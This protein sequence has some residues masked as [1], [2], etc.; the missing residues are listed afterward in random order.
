MRR[1]WVILTALAF[2]GVVGWVVVT[3]P[4]VYS[5]EEVRAT[6]RDLDAK[7][8]M[9]HES[10]KSV[11]PRLNIFQTLS[12]QYLGISG[13]AVSVVVFYG[14]RNGEARASCTVHYQDNG[15]VEGLYFNDSMSSRDLME[16]I[17]MKLPG[18][19]CRIDSP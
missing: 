19:R 15:K 1:K 18:I 6:L 8:I 9:E 5:S 10:T 3:S 13:S 12:H 2:I 4:K 14:F 11:N 16:F 7:W 17:Q